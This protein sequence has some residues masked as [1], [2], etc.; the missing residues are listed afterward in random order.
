MTTAAGTK[1]AP[2]A[3]SGKADAPSFATSPAIRA[4]RRPWLI[5]LGALLV[6]LGALAAVWLVGAAGQRQE[7]LAL[8]SAVPYGQAVSS[9][10]LS[11]VRVSVDPGIATVAASRRDEIV[12]Q[13]SATQLV[14]GMLLSPDM[15]E[16][17]GEPSDGQVLVPLAV[18]SDRM[19]AGGLRAGDRLLLVD[20]EPSGGMPD[21]MGVVVRVGPVDVNGLAV[22]DVTTPSSAGPGVAVAAAKGNVA[23]L[24]QP[25]GG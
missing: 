1:S 13:V 20:T 21:T 25:A 3:S 14:P 11:V 2:S 9:G 8:R 19:P 12:G 22:V 6:A 18:S 10:D 7:V 16:P 24:V 5:G 15:V 4:R 17:M 23:L